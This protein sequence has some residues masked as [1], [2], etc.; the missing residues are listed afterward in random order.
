M[1]RSVVTRP[2]VGRLKPLPMPYRPRHTRR[3]IAAP[4]R[5]LCATGATGSTARAAVREGGCC[6]RAFLSYPALFKHLAFDGSFLHGV[7]EPMQRDARPNEKDYGQPAN[8]LGGGDIERD[9]S[10]VASFCD[11]A[12]PRYAGG[13]GPGPAREASTGKS[14]VNVL[15]CS[16]LVKCNS[17]VLPDW[18]WWPKAVANTCA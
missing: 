8:R 1:P 5:Q 15:V 13:T 17:G 16:N 3:P 9:S 12:G 7:P 14:C 10:P 6:D 11:K 2:S 4:P 18:R